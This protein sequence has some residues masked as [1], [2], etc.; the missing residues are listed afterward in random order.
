MYESL[1]DL[2][3]QFSA[4][5]SFLFIEYADPIKAIK[6]IMKHYNIH[7]IY[8]N[9]DYTPFARK[10]YDNFSLSFPNIEIVEVNDYLLWE[11]GNV[12]NGQNQ[13]YSVFTPFYNS[14]KNK[15]YNKIKFPG[16]N[17][18]SKL[19][20]KSKVSSIFKSNQI[21]NMYKLKKHCYGSDLEYVG[22]RTNGIKVLKNLKTQVNY[23]AN[24][25]SLTYS[26]SRL[27]AYIKFGCL[28]IREIMTYIDIC[29]KKYNH[30][31]I[32]VASLDAIRR[33]VLWREFY[34]H[35]FIAYPD[36][37]E[38]NH[39]PNT[40][41]KLIPGKDHPIAV[42][43]YNQ[44]IETGYI[45]N[46]ARMI[47]AHYIL[48]QKKIYWK[49]GDLLFAQNL[50]DYD[51]FINI[52]NWLWINRQPKFKWLKMDT[53]ASKYDPKQEYIQKYSGFSK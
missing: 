20:K 29:L 8:M 50:I 1:V 7:K 14:I 46:R 35:Y 31:K 6:N 25:D 24:R 21:A 23:T 42:A 30:N 15:K 3:S 17:L 49:N 37:L 33:Q 44:L 10:R 40:V 38:W 34:Y 39:K 13:V 18:T 41:V 36:K 48:H 12:L 9:K 11:Y 52:G 28:S 22:G 43:C 45:N 32:F 16:K 5:N 47:L 2:I 19:I 53:Q 26:T 51:P 27:S 4:F